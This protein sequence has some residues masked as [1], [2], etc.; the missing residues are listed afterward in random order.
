M[1]FAVLILQMLMG[2]EPCPL[3]AL[4]RIVIACI[5]IVAVGGA[6]HNPIHQWRFLYALPIFI[7]GFVGCGICLWHMHLQNL[8]PDQVPSCGPGFDYIIDTFPLRKAL[9]IIFEGSGECAEKTWSFLG[10]TI[11]EQTLALFLAFIALSIGIMLNKEGRPLEF[12]RWTLAREDVAVSHES[13]A[14]INAPKRTTKSEANIANEAP[15]PEDQ[16]DSAEDEHPPETLLPDEDEDSSTPDD[17][18]K[19]ELPPS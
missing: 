9:A 1:A 4:D 7:L 14:P 18:I 19:P 11:P 5:A 16:K 2:L 10:L 3:C 12:A 17:D 15:A 6:V 13:S 8:P